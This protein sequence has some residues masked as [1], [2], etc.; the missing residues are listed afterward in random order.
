ME[1]K[2]KHKNG[3]FA[4]IRYDN[5]GLPIF[6]IDCLPSLNFD[7]VVPDVVVEDQVMLAFNVLITHEE[8]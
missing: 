5:K 3:T 4:I 1:K 8:I 2:F 7:L 6:V